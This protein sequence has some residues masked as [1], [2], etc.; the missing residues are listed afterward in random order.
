MTTP[1]S[2]TTII[3]LVEDNLIDF[4][5]IY[6][7]LTQL[8]DSRVEILHADTLA[9]GMQQVNTHSVDLVLLDLNLPDSEGLDTFIKMRQA[10]PHAPVVVLSGVDSSELALQAVQNGAQDY[11]IKGKLNADLLM[12]SLRH[13]IERQRWEKRVRETEAR[14]QNIFNGIRD[15]IL[16]ETLDGHVL[17]ANE[18][19]CRMYGYTRK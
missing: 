15:A 7:M 11:L 6:E 1:T 12:R 8:G 10:A 5:L 4:H 13:A 2:Q 17:D 9:G 3:L 19:A 18:S 14:Y 16:V